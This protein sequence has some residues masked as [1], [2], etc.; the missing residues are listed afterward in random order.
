[1][2]DKL[3]DEEDLDVRVK[4]TLLVYAVVRDNVTLLSSL[5]DKFKTNV[6]E[7]LVVEPGQTYMHKAAAAGA[8]RCVHLLAERGS[9]LDTANPEGE[10]AL[11]LAASCGHLGTNCHPLLFHK[12]I[13]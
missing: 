8:L 2:L 6:K 3:P 4:E 13:V 7:A 5:L 11:H 10:T 1:M 9:A 12:C